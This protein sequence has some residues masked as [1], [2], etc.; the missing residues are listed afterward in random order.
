LA[1]KTAEIEARAR[2]GALQQTLEE[3]VIARF[4]TAP[5]ILLRDMRRIGD[6]DR[7]RE[8]VVAVIQAA[9]LADF[10]QR[11]HAAVDAA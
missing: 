2:T 8:L 9:D 6:A 4:P 5:L 7:L 3:A 11:L 10:E 1:D